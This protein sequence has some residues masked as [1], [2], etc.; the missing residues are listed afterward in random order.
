MAFGYLVER[1]ITTEKNS[2]QFLEPSL[3]KTNS[4][5]NSSRG[6]PLSLSNICETR[7]TGRVQN[8]ACKRSKKGLRQRVSQSLLMGICSASLGRNGLQAGLIGHSVSP[9]PPFQAIR[10]LS[11]TWFFGQPYLGVNLL[12]YTLNVTQSC[13]RK[14]KTVLSSSFPKEDNM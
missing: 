9:R 5:R 6:F 8:T 13:S 3:D 11:H 2:R 4:L 10:E 7:S 1:I 14:S 12:N